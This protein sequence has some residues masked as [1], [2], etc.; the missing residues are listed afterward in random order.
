MKVAVIS[1][2]HGNHHGLEA[3]LSDIEKEMPDM[4]VCAGDFICP[5]PDSFK[6][7]QTLKKE[8]IP[9]IRGNQEE[10]ILR[11]FSHKKFPVMSSSVRYWPI[12]FIAQ[13]MTQDN[14]TEIEKLPLTLTIDGPSGE[15]V[16]VCHGMP[17]TPW[18]SYSFGIDE[19]RAMEL[20]KVQE[21]TIVGGH[22]H[23]QWQ[24]IWEDK[25]LV[26]VGSG[27]M[28]LTGD[29]NTVLYSLLEHKGTGWEVIPKIVNY[30]SEGAIQSVL[31][32][33]FLEIAGP[34]GWLMFEELCTQVNHLT[35][36]FTKYCPQPI[37]DDANLDVWEKLVVDYLTNI[38]RW[39]YVKEYL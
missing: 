23:Q 18:W 16:L 34:V 2:F 21:Q 9:L 33:D 19:D 29:T 24:E 27:G 28:P 30:N 26:V 6:V 5:Y 36:F 31:N 3:I 14:L 38:G 11:Y 39:D 37:P 10:Y 32:S 25:L 7:W 20:R 35:P 17:N 1:D 8:N 15:D 4:V 13:N 22:H 12:K